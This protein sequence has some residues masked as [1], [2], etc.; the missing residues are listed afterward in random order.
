MITS[1]DQQ[2]GAVLRQ[3]VKH[4][5]QCQLRQLG[6]GQYEIDSKKLFLIKY[7]GRES[8][9]NFTVRSKEVQTLVKY[10]FS[11]FFERAFLVLNCGGREVCVLGFDDWSTV[12]DI[13]RPSAQQTI[14][15]RR[16]KNCGFSV[17]GSGGSLDRTI[18]KS[19]LSNVVAA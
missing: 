11:S 17:S 15:L 3:I 10:Q 18:P 16:S 9:W 14:T 5:E 8:F 1:R 13:E 4:G 12:L 2:H 19:R 6:S 7:C